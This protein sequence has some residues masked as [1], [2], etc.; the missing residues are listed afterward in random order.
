MSLPSDFHNPDEVRIFIEESLA[1]NPR[2][3]L[4]ILEI[5][6]RVKDTATLLGLVQI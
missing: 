1:D 3:V 5:A 4:H 2:R 6:L